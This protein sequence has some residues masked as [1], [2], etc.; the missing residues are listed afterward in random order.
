MGQ[1]GSALF[2]PRLEGWASA[3]WGVVVLMALWYL[4]R[5]WNEQRESAGQLK[6]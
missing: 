4:L 1:F 6:S 2:L 3:V 5:S